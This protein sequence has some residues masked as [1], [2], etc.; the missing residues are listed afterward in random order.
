MADV[1]V[2]RDDDEVALGGQL[3]HPLGLGVEEAPL[4][5]LLRGVD[6]AG[7][8]VAAHDGDDVLAV[9]HIDLEP[10]AGRVD[11]VVAERAAHLDGSVAGEHGDAGATLLVALVEGDVPLGGNERLGLLDR[12][13]HLLHGDDVGRAFGDP[14]G[15]ALTGGGAD[16]V[17]VDRCDAKRHAGNPIGAG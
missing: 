2:A 7:V 3:A 9:L 15:Q 16:S 8:C 10:A 5:L 12:G 6:L 17:H 14:V 1:E 11:R 13:A 4:R